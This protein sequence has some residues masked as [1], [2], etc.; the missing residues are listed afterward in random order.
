[1]R[2]TGLDVSG[3]YRQ[4]AWFIRI[5]WFP[6]L[7]AI[8]V[9]VI[10]SIDYYLA[11]RHIWPT[12]P[13][14]FALGSFLFVL[15]IGVLKDMAQSKCAKLIQL[16]ASSKHILWGYFAIAVLSLLFALHPTML[17]NYTLGET[18]FLYVYSMVVLL[19]SYSIA[20]FQ[21][22]RSNIKVIFVLALLVYFGSIVADLFVPNL[23]TNVI[24]R[25]AGF[26]VNPNT[27]ALTLIMLM[28]ASADWKAYKITDGFLWMMTA[29]GVFVTF[30][31]GGL[32][33]FFISFTMYV[34]FAFFKSKSKKKM[35]QAAITLF[36]IYACIVLLV[37]PLLGQ[38]QLFKDYTA[39]K[40]FATITQLIGGD[41]DTVKDDS[42]ID[43]VDLYLNKISNSPIVGYGSG[44]TEKQPIGPHNMYLQA[45][46]NL[47][48]AGIILLLYF[49]AALFAYF[50][51][52]RDFRGVAFTIVFVLEGFFAHDLLLY[53]PFIVLLGI[54]IALSHFDTSKGSTAHVYN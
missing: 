16:Y 8:S 53:R 20:I 9:L 23:F 46:I 43:L 18:S 2:P 41:S 54:L 4:M 44:Y 26:A 25:A 39:Q 51:R 30:S 40:R 48:A 10:C 37:I 52:N 24:G 15:Y 33:I 1:M 47:G 27:G 7:T 19:A 38:G 11:R 36:I 50:I 5:F 34:Y 28:V 6:L 21:S 42:R 12:T 22:I 35:I 49:I 3:S 45:W 32:L 14:T 13:T 17:S 29:V 31:R